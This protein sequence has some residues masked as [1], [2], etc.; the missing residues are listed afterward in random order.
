MALFS[1]AGVALATAGLGL[2]GLGMSVGNL[3]LL[4][5]SAFPLSLLAWSLA[6]RPAGDITG[7]RALSTAAPRRGERVE[8]TIRTETP[9]AGDIIEVHAPLPESASL[10]GA[11]TNL[12]A[13]HGAGAR[14]LVVG[15]RVHKRGPVMLP[16][17][18]AERIDALG[19]L[20]PRVGE[21]APPLAMRVAPRG[22]PSERLRRKGAMALRVQPTR[23]GIGSADFRELRD[24][25]WGD[26][27]KSIHWRATAR[28][29]SAAAGRG[30][31]AAAPIVKEY[32]KE[33]RRAALVLLDGG[34][35]LRI[36]TSLESGLDHAVE[37][38]LA[39]CRLL[40]AAGVRVGA[41]TYHAKGATPEPPESGAGQMPQLERA[42]SPGEPDPAAGPARALQQLT[43]HLRGMR[44][45][46]VVVTRVT[47]ANAQGLAELAGQ[48]RVL[49]RERAKRLPLVVL[50][51][52]ALSLVPSRGEA[53]DAAAALVARE[54]GEAARRVEGLGARVLPWK[55]GDDVHA[56]LAREGIA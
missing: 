11:D 2:L 49:L 9:R 38:A 32:D 36:G 50:D 27:P 31:A 52:R 53:W 44:P 13:H 23:L 34:E 41:A 26:P 21:V 8:M 25:A 18:T 46:V 1:R 24:Y 35:S 55:P 37:A 30:G 45:V 16:A 42:L 40:L 29:L 19:L 7:Q 10:E 56:L 15:F 33:G 47:P 12:A 20:A 4:I 6:T 17:V 3:S 28:R 22:Y 14:G 54:D 5:L 39:A 43:P 51:V 48:M